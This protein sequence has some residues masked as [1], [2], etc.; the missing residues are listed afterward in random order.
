MERER[1]PG[2]GAA[3]SEPGPDADA[4]SLSQIELVLRRAK[5]LDAEQRSPSAAGLSADEVTRIALEAGLSPE[6]VDGALREL[7][8]GELTQEQKL[9]LLD[10]HIGPRVVR[11]GRV[12]DLPPDEAAAAIRRSFEI[13][14]L[15]PLERQG[16]RTIWAPQEGL[17]AN[18]L[19]TVRHGWEGRR[20]FRRVE[21]IS[22][23]RAADASGQRSIVSLEAR[24]EGRGPLAAG[25]IMVA[26]ISALATVGL[27]GT[28]FAHLVQHVPDATQLLVGSGAMLAGGTGVSAL[29]V[30]STARAWRKRL[31]RVH[32]SLDKLLD[33]L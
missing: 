17:R 30:S 26:A 5:Q 32:A 9:A 25:P 28:G 18:V 13:E 7:K 4:L 8:V 1:R 10:K 27:A 14:L 20:A 19:R 23:V 21:L 3:A 11:A 33:G 12:I 24:L 22:D 6:A 2:A 16:R 29:A 31:R 15:E